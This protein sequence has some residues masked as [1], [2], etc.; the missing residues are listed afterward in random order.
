MNAEQSDAAAP[1]VGILDTT[2][3]LV[4]ELRETVHDQLQLVVLESERAARSL[5]VMLAAEVA[6][7]TLLVSTWLCLIGAGVFALM[8]MGV[9]PALA[10]TVAAGLTLVGVLVPYRVIRHQRRHL[11]FPATLAS[12]APSPPRGG[13][14]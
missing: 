8:S 1:S 14:S 7:G 10:L 3:A 13:A 6:I 9:G 4:H 5:V 11:R 2:V 12:L